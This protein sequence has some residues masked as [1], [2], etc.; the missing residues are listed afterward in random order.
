M[1][2]GDVPWS[3]NR[4]CKGIEPE[5]V[6]RNHRAASRH[7]ITSDPLPW[8]DPTTIGDT[9]EVRWATVDSMGRIYYEWKPRPEFASDPQ[10]PDLGTTEGEH[11]A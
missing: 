8:F 5:W 1:S 3:C 10:S 6:A 4:G 11:N 7:K 2:A 9:P